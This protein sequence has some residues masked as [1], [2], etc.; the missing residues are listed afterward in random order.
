MTTTTHLPDC[1]LEAREKLERYLAM[2]KKIP[3]AADSLPRRL[4]KQILPASVHNDLQRLATDAIRFRE[5]RKAERLLGQQ[6]LRLNLGSADR[7]KAGWVN[8][9]MVGHPVELALNIV[10]PLPFPDNSVD[11][12]FHEYVLTTL[13]FPD[14]V[15]LTRECYR[16]LKPGGVLRLGVEDT[17]AYVRSL[18]V[19]GA[20]GFIESMRPGRPTPLLGVLDVFFAWTVRW[21]YDFDTLALVCNAV[22]FRTVE[23]SQFGES[24]I[25]PCPDGEFRRHGTLWVEAVKE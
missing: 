3:A 11:A 22:G 7:C 4:L 10:R 13:S 17:T 20:D 15:A 23:H 1:R 5:V 14:A 18:V 21:L 9:D 16:I 2:P 12:V 8:I 19:D 25:T 6:P 24:R